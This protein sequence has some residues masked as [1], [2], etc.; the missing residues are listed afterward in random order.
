MPAASPVTF[1]AAM[2][3]LRILTVD[4]ERLALRRLQLLLQT[5]PQVEHVGEA[6]NSWEAIDR[7]DQLQPNLILLDIKMRGGS[8]FE[9]VE[10]MAS[11]RAPPAIVL[12]TAFDQFAARA[13]DSPVVDYLVKPVERER[14]TRALAR[15]RSRL[16]AADAEQ[17][18]EELQ[19][20]LSN[21]RAAPK[22]GGEQ[23]YETEFWLRNSTGLVRVPVDS[24]EYVTSADV[25]V[26]IHARSGVHLMRGSIRQFEDRV[27]PGLFVRV[28]RR[29]LVRRSAI[30]ELSTSAPGRLEVVLHSGLRLPA[31][32]VHAKA[33]RK[34]M[35]VGWN[36]AV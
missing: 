32:R 22:I 10:A 33:L 9:V 29:A 7:I 5:I 30:A 18:A 12:V 23:P 1:G 31:G 3:L 16:K 25:Y 8:G 28:H 34:L 19:Q 11:R 4:D 15:V 6:G 26:S 14:L 27:E 24:I 2:G 17:R 36:P 13:F 35:R 21:V 20:I